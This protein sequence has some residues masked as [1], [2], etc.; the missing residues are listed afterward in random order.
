MGHILISEE[1]RELLGIDVAVLM[2]ANIASEIASD[3]FAEATIGAFLFYCKE[4]SQE[5]QM[6]KRTAPF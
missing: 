2:G 1:I 6:L 3:K 4:P 5:R